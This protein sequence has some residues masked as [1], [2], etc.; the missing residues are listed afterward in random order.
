MSKNGWDYDPAGVSPALYEGKPVGIDHR[1]RGE[2]ASSYDGFGRLVN[3]QKR[4]D[5]IYGDIEYLKTHSLA[6]PITEAAERMPNLYGLSHLGDGKKVRR[7]GKMVVESVTMIESIDLVRDPAT[8]TSLF[9]SQSCE[10]RPMRH[11]TIKQLIEYLQD[12]P[13]YTGKACLAALREQDEAG[14][15][16]MAAPVE[17]PPPDASADDTHKAAF[18]SMVMAVLDDDSLDIKGKMKKIK[19]ILKAEEKLTGNGEGGGGGGGGE[20]ET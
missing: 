12:R 15:G 2:D 17:A 14:M 13:E 11:G 8:V 3:V 18:R 7:K 6:G 4:D 16:E 9:E 1:K 20:S 19:D 5:G 10:E